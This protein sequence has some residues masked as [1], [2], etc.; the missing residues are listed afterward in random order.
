MIRYA[1]TQAELRQRINDTAPTWLDKARER[2][3]AYRVAG[4]Y[5][6]PPSDIWSDIKRVYME[7]QGYK[8]G[9]CER[10]LERSEFGNVEHDV[11]HFR[12]K[13]M[14]EQWPPSS[15][16]ER[17]NGLNFTLG[18][19]SP[20][21]GYFLL[22]HEPDNYLISCKTCN[23]AFKSNG[24]PVEGARDLEMESPRHTNERPLLVYP[25]G[26]F[27]DDPRKLI[28]F[29]GIVPVP[30]AS[31]GRRR[32]RGQ[33]LISFFGLAERDGLL[34]ERSITIVNLHLALNSAANPDPTGQIAQHMLQVLTSDHAAHANCARSFV[35]LWEADQAD[36]LA[37]SE[38]A[39]D[40]LLSVA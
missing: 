20:G 36:A 19:A 9:F 8:C 29:E 14:V 5:G 32:K 38:A 2:T 39:L 27:D 22:P 6:K 17:G 18:D 3:E 1:V 35:A 12:L 23:T 10:R 31:S 11:E 40:H 33:T 26:S 16:P 15:A 21:L 30:A 13:G 25:I 37:F 4:K 34:L 28:R 24:F 7:L